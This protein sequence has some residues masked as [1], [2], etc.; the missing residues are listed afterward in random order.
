MPNL[1]E[2]N[3]SEISK[4]NKR[5]KANP[6]DHMLY[7]HRANCYRELYEEGK[8]HDD[9]TT[10]LRINPKSKRALR[11]RA[12]LFASLKKY[13]EALA[14]YNRIIQLYP[15]DCDGYMNRS[16]L[17][18]TLKQDKLALADLNRA[19]KLNPN[20]RLALEY[21]GSLYERIGRYKDALADYEHLWKTDQ[22]RSI[23]WIQ[24]LA[25]C[26]LKAGD[27]QSAL[28]NY[29]Q[30]IAINAHDEF[31]YLSRGNL[32]FQLKQY[33]KAVADY[34]RALNET[35]DAP[36]AILMARSQAYEKLGMHD[37]AA[38]DA[39]QARKPIGRGR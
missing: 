18:S 3:E 22:K 34:T 33:Q 19:L 2:E 31:A 37:K 20:R 17:Y 10:A 12:N 5:I 30:L 11:E 38:Q 9:Y 28:A 14:D 29:S 36:D 1:D 25:E 8:A 24:R 26:H 32:Y 27:K 7:V 35:V 16:L 23:K 15:D 6:G 39:A 13:D 21:R 4:I